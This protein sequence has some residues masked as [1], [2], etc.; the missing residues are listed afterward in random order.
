MGNYIK[1]FI[2]DTYDG[3]RMNIFRN[4]ENDSTSISGNIATPLMKK[5]IEVHNQHHRSKIK[6]MTIDQPSGTLVDISIQL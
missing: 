3:Y 2:I 4:I 6:V 1:I 5:K